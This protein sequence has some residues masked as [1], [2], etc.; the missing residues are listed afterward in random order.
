[1]AGTKGFAPLNTSFIKTRK[2]CSYE[3]MCFAVK[4]VP[5]LLLSRRLKAIKAIFIDRTIFFDKNLKIYFFNYLIGLAI[6]YL[7]N[8]LIHQS[9]EVE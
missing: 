7:L 1:M 4:L 5:E 2:T 8:F 6:V 3:G 9:L